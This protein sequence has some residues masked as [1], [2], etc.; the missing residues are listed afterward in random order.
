MASIGS[1]KTTQD[2]IFFGPFQLFAAERRLER[3]GVPVP[4][5]SRAFDI[6]LILLEKAPEVVDKRDLLAAVWRNLTVEDGSL[7]FHVAALRKALDDGLSGARY[8]LNVPGRG[9][10]FGAPVSRGMVRPAA[11]EKQPIRTSGVGLPGTFRRM[12]GRDEAARAIAEELSASRFV[13]IVGPGGIGKTTLALAVAHGL[14]ERFG[15]AVHFIDLGAVKAP[16][17]VPNVIASVVGL[18]T[19][20]DDP[21]PALLAFLRDRTRLLVLDT[22]EHLIETV[23]MLAESIFNEVPEAYILATSRESLRVEGEYVHRLPPLDYP[24]ESSGLTVE[25]ALA[26]PAVQLFVERARASGA[27]LHLADDDGPTLGGICQQLDGIALAIELAAGQVEA[28]GLRGISTLLDSQFSLLWSG[29]RT[30]LP[31]HQTLTAT[32]DWSYKLLTETERAVL[33]RLAVFAGSFSLEAAQAVTETGH[34]AKADVVGAI[35]SLVAKSLLTTDDSARPLRYRLLD[36]TRAYA[37]QKLLEAEEEA[38]IERRRALYLVELFKQA[39]GG[40]ESFR[41]YIGDARTA[42]E[43]GFSDHGDTETGISLVIATAPVFLNQS[44]LPECRS[45]TERAIA[46]LGAADRGT[47]RELQLSSNY[48]ISAAYSRGPTPDVQVALTRSLELAEALGDDRSLL[49]QLECLHGGMIVG[50]DWE[51]AF[52]VALRC[53]SVAHSLGDPA[54]IAIADCHLCLSHFHVGNLAAA[55]HYC[56]RVIQ[57]APNRTYTSMARL[58]YDSPLYGLLVLAETSWIQGASDRALTLVRQALEEVEAGSHQ[59]VYSACLIFVAD[60]HLRVGDWETA[61][62]AIQRLSAE[63][64]KYLLAPHRA[65]AQCLQGRL[66]LARGDM[67]SGIAALREGFTTL[68]AGRFLIGWRLA[69]PELAE[70]LVEMGQYDQALAIIQLDLDGPPRMLHSPELMRIKA[71]ALASGPHNDPAAAEKCLLEALAAAQSQGMLSWELRIAMTLA[72]LWRERGRVAEGV[73]LVAAVYQQFT[74]GLGT[75]DLVLA[76]RILT[77]LKH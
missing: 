71:R 14:I 51:G 3:E 45:W 38:T 70:A 54:E 21:I 52:P 64:E 34:L 22:C 18:A 4:L 74:E 29:R 58:G 7:R 40:N 37:R 23:A 72:E 47:Y 49:R 48:A 36:T 67:A 27:T 69:T 2:V 10:S 12:V 75:P 66:L 60:I 59:V 19:S 57:N 32:L 30:A 5:G 73:A 9:Y 41:P 26:F 63:T 53:E 8:I 56:E 31:R 17:L 77:D 44:L 6:L 68:K 43:W 24:P 50:G 39:E 25:A 15:G 16:N 1:E 11:V 20:D 35:A 28:H 33:R 61:A 76:K 62:E 42:L 46:A 13:T 55:Q 65:I